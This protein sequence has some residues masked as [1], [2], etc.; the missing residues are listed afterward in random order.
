MRRLL[1]SAPRALDASSDFFSPWAQFAIL[2]LTVL[3]SWEQVRAPSDPPAVAG[4]TGKLI[5]QNVLV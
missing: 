4:L 1:R 2:R 5:S 3:D